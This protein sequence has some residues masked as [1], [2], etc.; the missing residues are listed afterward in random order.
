M[1]SKPFGTAASVLC[2][3]RDPALT[4]AGPPAIVADMDTQHLSG[5]AIRI[6]DPA[7]NGLPG[8]RDSSAVTLEEHACDVRS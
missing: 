7:P 4:P 1:E 8:R 2:D 3:R 6:S 5:L